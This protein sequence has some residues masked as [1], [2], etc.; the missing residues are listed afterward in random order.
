MILYFLLPLPPL[1]PPSLSPHED[2]MA[3]I[4]LKVRPSKYTC[5]LLLQGINQPIRT[6]RRLRSQPKARENAS[7]Q[8]AI[9]FGFDWLEKRARTL[10]QSLLCK[11]IPKHR[12]SFELCVIY[13]QDIQQHVLMRLRSLLFGDNADAETT[14][15]VLEYFMRRLSSVQ[16]A[17]RDSAVKVSIAKL[18]SLLLLFLSAGD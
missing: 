16:T 6:R 18:F 14:G 1:F 15:E 8:V 10:S 7:E 12:W 5:K 17:E 3:A 11:K 2:K 9:T 13:T 4:R